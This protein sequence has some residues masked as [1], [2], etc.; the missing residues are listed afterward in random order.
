[1]ELPDWTEVMQERFQRDYAGQEPQYV[2]MLNTT[3]QLCHSL[4]L[5]NQGRIQDLSEGGGKIF[6]EQKNS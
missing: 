4:S 5:D 3:N 2:G 1:M 6:K